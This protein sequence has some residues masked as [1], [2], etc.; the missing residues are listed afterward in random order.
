M[1]EFNNRILIVDDNPSIHR[2]F[3]KIL[4]SHFESDG[5][6]ELL[7]DVLGESGE[8]LA[9]DMGVSAANLEHT[10]TYEL[11]HATQGEEAIKKA[12]GAMEMG[13][14]YA[15]IFMDV[16]MPPGMDGITAIGEIWKTCPNTE[17]VICTAF[18]DYSW[19][20]ILQR[21]GTSDQVQFLRKPFDVVSIKQ[22]AMALVKKW[23][24]SRQSREYTLDLE[25]E[26]GLRTQEL[27]EK[28][29]ALEKAMAEI[30]TLQGILPMCAYCHKVRTD[31]DY[32]ERVDEYIRART[33]AEISHGVCPE[34][35]E[36]LLAEIEQE[37]PG[38]GKK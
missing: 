3:E 15:L 17:M 37:N 21:I 23:N 31:G 34:C 28:I 16:R 19:E 12:A 24:L 11:E 1:S 9:S 4:P 38:I 33:P 2:D 10:L 7:Q 6:D 14:P 8:A 30:R 18:S 22:M 27:Q 32:W 20:E 25:R 36:K 5:L 26:V 35:Y 29:T 13:K